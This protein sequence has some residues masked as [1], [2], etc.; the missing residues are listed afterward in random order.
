M[1]CYR[2]GSV[3]G[4]GKY[5]LRCGADV[6]VYRRIVRASNGYYNVGL[7]KAKVR[8]LTGAVEA[9]SRA[10][11]LH[12]GNTQARNLLGLVYY[13]LGEVTETLICWRVSLELQPENNPAK[14]LLEKLKADGNLFSSQAQGLEKYNQALTYAR[15]GSEDLAVLQ[16][17][18]V[19]KNHPKHVKSHALLA[20]M[21]IWEQR[22]DRAEKELKWILKVDR[23]NTF[24]K[25]LGKELGDLKKAGR[26]GAR[27]ASLAKKEATLPDVPAAQ[28]PAEEKRPKLPARAAFWLRLA[29]VIAAV[30]LCW[31]LIINPTVRRRRNEAVNRLAGLYAAEVQELTQEIRDLKIELAELKAENASRSAVMEDQDARLTEMEAIRAEIAKYESVLTMFRFDPEK[32]REVLT[33][34]F[35]NLTEDKLDSEGYRSVYRYWEVTLGFAQEEETGETAP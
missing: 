27:S 3:L 2:C 15:Q 8:D 5:C 26:A 23:G 19:L 13:E 31:I 32:D 10:V 29:A 7:E 24:A 33:A 1:L 21:E 28:E 20:L 22:Y 12:K 6:S 9:L 35:R 25:S 30:L 18:R 14:E 4:A 17:Q 11:E 16:L 34:M